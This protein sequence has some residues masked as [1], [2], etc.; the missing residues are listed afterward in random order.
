M[1][2]MLHVSCIIICLRV[3]FLQQILPLLPTLMKLSLQLQ[4]NVVCE[5]VQNSKEPS[6]LGRRHLR[7]PLLARTSTHN[8]WHTAIVIERNVDNNLH[9]VK[10]RAFV[11]G[12]SAPSGRT[13]RG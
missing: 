8:D 13:E 1:Y 12:W 11:L 5:A 4:C 3:S 9:R 2:Y 6:V 10:W 7:C